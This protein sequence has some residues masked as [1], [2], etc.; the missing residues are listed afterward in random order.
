MIPHEI[1]RHQ[2][3]PQQIEVILH[4]DP[5]LFWFSGHFAVQPLL[6]GV[7]QMD[8]VMH[9]A[10]TLL[11]PGWRFRSIQ[12]VKFQA[13]LLPENTVTLTLS[14]QEARQLLTFSY[15]RHDGDARHTASSGKIR[16]CR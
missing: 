14:W 10:T 1:E 7:A 11:A 3:H 13:P 6:P 15:Q 9:Y 16:L 4:L 2:A 12:N 5:S 8:W